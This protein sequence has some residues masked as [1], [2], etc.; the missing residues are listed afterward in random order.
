MSSWTAQDLRRHDADC[1]S[2]GVARRSAQEPDVRVSARKQSPVIPSLGCY[3]QCMHLPQ[4]GVL[5]PGRQG[6]AGKA[7]RLAGDLAP[8]AAVLLQDPIRK[9][10]STPSSKLASWYLAVFSG[11]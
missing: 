3:I 5:A 4:A 10:V 9:W 2:S 1:Q 7:R 11:I 8:A 6:L